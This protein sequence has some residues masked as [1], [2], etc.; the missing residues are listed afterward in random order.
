MI[1]NIILILTLSAIMAALEYN[2]SKQWES[3][4]QYIFYGDTNLTQS[5]VNVFFSCYLLLNQFVPL[6]LLIILEMVQIL[7]V[8]FIDS[9]VNM[10][11]PVENE[12]AGTGR[13]PRF[14]LSGCQSQSYTLHEDLGQVNFLFC[15]KTGTLTKN[16][17]VF[18]KWTCSGYEDPD[19]QPELDALARDKYANFL[20]CITLCHDVLVLNLPNKDGVDTWTKSGS[21]QDELCFL[22]MVEDKRIAELVDRD[23]EKVTIRI[24]GREEVWKTIKVYEFTSERKMMTVI[25]QNTQTRK[26]M[27]FSKGASDSISNCADP[28]T[29]RDEE[30]KDIN[31]ATKFAK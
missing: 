18:K 29:L 6:E 16:E 1:V 23:S 28:E 17:L 13:E 7:V 26:Y 31:F 30:F 4:A 2:F 5:A 8:Q 15:D 12:L 27:V 11:H 3:G 22:D 10:M 24:Q 21:S 19:L 14:R 9:D 20:R 25:M